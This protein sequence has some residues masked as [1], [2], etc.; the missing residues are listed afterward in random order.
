MLTGTPI[1]NHLGELWSLFEFLNPGVLGRSHLFSRAAA[2][3]TEESDAI[4]V[5]VS[6]ERGVVSIAESGAIIEGLDAKS[7]RER[8]RAALAPREEQARA[9]KRTRLVF[10]R[11]RDA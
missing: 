2:G 10:T 1:E 9:G 3:I 4:A 6:E 7:L 8:L 5:V 11:S